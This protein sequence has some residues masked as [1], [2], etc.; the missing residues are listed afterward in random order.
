L[1]PRHVTAEP[2]S[3]HTVDPPTTRFRGTTLTGLEAGEGGGLV[4]IGAKACSVPVRACWPAAGTGMPDPLAG[5]L[6][7]IGL[8]RGWAIAV[9]VTID[10]TSDD[11]AAR[12]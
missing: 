9:N 1:A 7:S 2:D 3:T 4:S 12:R 6:G 11:V 5:G 10:S 8:S